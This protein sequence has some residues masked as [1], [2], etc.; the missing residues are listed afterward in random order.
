[1]SIIHDESSRDDPRLTKIAS[2]S[3]NDLS[4]DEMEGELPAK[5]GRYDIVQRVGRGGLCQVLLG[6]DPRLD[7]DVAIKV[8]RTNRKISDSVWREFLHEARSAAKLRHESI[9][10]MIDVDRTADGTP[11]VVMEYVD[12]INLYRYWQDREFRV[13]ETIRIVKQIATGLQF[14]HEHGIVH[15]DLKPTNIIIDRNGNARIADFGLALELNASRSSEPRTE[16]AGTSRFMSPEQLSGESH[17]IDERTDL[18]GLGVILYWL[19]TGEYPF[20]GEN[21]PEL[22]EQ[23]RRQTQLHLDQINVAIP[24]D[25]DRICRRCLAVLRQDRYPSAAAFIEDLDR[26]LRNQTADEFRDA[27]LPKHHFGLSQARHSENDGQLSNVVP[28]GLQAYDENDASFYLELLPGPRDGFGIPECLRYWVSRYQGAIGDFSHGLIYGPPGCGKTSFLRAGLIPQLPADID[29]IYVECSADQTESDLEQLIASRLNIQ[30]VIGRQIS[31]LICEIREGEHLESGRRLLLILDQFEQFL[32]SSS[33]LASS[34]LV[35]ALRQCDGIRIQCLFAVRDDYWTQTQEFLRLQEIQIQDGRN[36]QALPLFDLRH[37]ENVLVRFGQAYGAIESGE[38]V[39]NSTYTSFAKQSIAAIADHG[40]VNCGHLAILAA[41]ISDRTWSATELSRLGGWQG[42]VVR[43]MNE[44]YSLPN[45]PIANRRLL[46]QIRQIV[47]ELLPAHGETTKSVGKSCS[48]LREACPVGTTTEAFRNAIRSL[49][50]DCRFIKSV[51]VLDKALSEDQQFQLSHDILCEPLRAWLHQ[52]NRLTWQ[53]RAQTDLE[54]YTEIWNCRR[55]K[56][57]LPSLLTLARIKLGMGNKAVDGKQAEFLSVAWRYQLSKWAAIATTLA[58]LVISLG[59][60][61]QHQRA[62]LVGQNQY[63]EFLRSDSD[64]ALVMLGEFKNQDLDVENLARKVSLK[65]CRE[66]LRHATALFCLGENKSDAAANVLEL[67]GEN[68]PAEYIN[69]VRYLKPELKEMRVSTNCLSWFENATTLESRLKYAVVAFELGDSMLVERIIDSSTPDPTEMI[70]L[71]HR[72]SEFGTISTDQLAERIIADDE[73]FS[74]RMFLL[75]MLFVGDRSDSL[76]PARKKQVLDF[77]RDVYQTSELR[78]AHSIAKWALEINDCELPKIAAGDRE[79]WRFLDQ[80]ITL[81]KVDGGK[82]ETKDGQQAIGEFFVSDT[83]TTLEV[84]RRFLQ[85]L[86]YEGER[87]LEKDFQSGHHKRKHP[88]VWEF[89][90]SAAPTNLHPVV[91]VSVVQAAMFCNWLSTKNGLQPVYEINELG[92]KTNQDAHGF[93]LPTEFE[94]EHLCRQGC[95][96]DTFIG[97]QVDRQ[98]IAYYAAFDE[99]L[100]SQTQHGSGCYRCGIRLPGNWGLFD[101]VGNV[102]E[103]AVTPSED[104]TSIKCQHLG[105][106]SYAPVSYVFDGDPANKK[107]NPTSASAKVG[108]RVLLESSM[109]R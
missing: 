79:Q 70:N 22:Q 106:A 15:R 19:C 2:P 1:M 37:A 85:D 65:T 29:V 88:R 66:Q 84:F 60:V 69:I 21:F 51:A 5:I 107:R 8:P 101:T 12:G 45:A 63:E 98:W 9:I 35:A 73:P 13:D 49:E 33:S 30:P 92:I 18:W 54:A 7:R 47:K 99:E 48:Q 90:K 105:L 91:R 38:S 68:D 103:I 83:E 10:S 26:L 100:R 62:E 52:E 82:F 17:R 25:L 16:I 41:V 75:S 102:A 20:Q 42:I 27:T 72:F 67:I 87:P 31:E 93:R 104:G 50:R 3:S 55:T 89:D 24:R 4:D 23:I 43:F 40:K 76:Q 11:F 56:Q 94:F 57:A 61:Y 58:A 34:K 109:N 80:G 74:V 64:N 28:K 81:I 6:H 39:A 59:Y 77:A 71:R 78:S 108:F 86:E 97:N 53:G 36:S 14:V 95:S 44:Q 46:P 96:A 32:S